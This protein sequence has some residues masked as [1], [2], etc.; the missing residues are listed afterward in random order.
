MPSRLIPLALLLVALLAPA[1]ASAQQ[2]QV[3]QGYFGAVADGVLTDEDPQRFE[4]ELPRMVGAGVESLRMVFPWRDAQPYKTRAEIP[5]D[6]QAFFRDEGGVPTDWRLL[7]GYVEHAARQGLTILPV[8]LYAPQ[9]AA[10][11]G[12]SDASPPRGHTDY[13]RFVV[14][15]AKRYGR[16]GTFWTERPDVPRLP[17]DWLQI[18]NEPHFKEYWSDQPWEADYA[19]L[20]RGT[21]RAVK[22]EVPSAKILVAGMANKSW[23]YIS[24]LYAQKTRG[25]FDGIAMHPF[26]NSIDG[27]VEIIERGRRVM[28][29]NG[30][31]KLPLMITEMSWTSAK[32]KAGYT[33]G[34]ERTEAGQAKALR[35]GLQRM[36]KD[37]RALRILHVYWYTWMTRDKHENIPFDYAGVI[38]FESDGTTTEKPAFAAY[39]STA[40]ALEGCAGKPSG[41][42]SC[43]PRR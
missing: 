12:N 42:R 23:T 36:A 9:W 26:T 21:Y 5:S 3:P 7:D 43:T 1:R 4:N 31:G 29:R 16:S 20:L 18:W 27:V 25:Y 33:Y 17:I 37:R 11:Y 41:A 30:D 6:Q 22:K 24:K 8:V 39:R 13:A 32:G 15:V 35:Q 28:A 34:N 2:R 14:A 40:M 10:K 19:R 38:R